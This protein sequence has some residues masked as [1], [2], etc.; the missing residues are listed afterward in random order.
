MLEQLQLTVEV[1]VVA[2]AAVVAAV[3]AAIPLTVEV[4]FV[5]RCLNNKKH[6][7]QFKS[8]AGIYISHVRPVIYISHLR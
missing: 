4:R 5:R 3:V 2:A 7:F 1:A 6:N 8:R